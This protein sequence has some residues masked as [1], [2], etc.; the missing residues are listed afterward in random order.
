MAALI[1]VDVQY[2]FLPGGALAV[3]GSDAIL[4]PILNDLLPSPSSSSSPSNPWRLIIATQ[5]YHPPRHISFASIHEGAKVR[6]TRKVPHPIVKG[7][8]IEQVMWPDHCVRGTRGA[9]IEERVVRRLREVKEG[10]GEVAVVQKVGPT[11]DKLASSPQQADYMLP[12]PASHTQGTDPLVDGY[13][14]LSDNAYSRFT[15]LIRYLSSHSIEVVVVCG[16]A[17]DYC[18]LYT[19]MDLVKFGYTVVLPKDATRPVEAQSGAVEKLEAAGMR[20]VET[21]R[22]AREVVREMVSRVEEGR[23]KR[24]LEKFEE[25]QRRIWEEI[26]S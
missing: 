6:E 19:A 4:D 7:E 16:L 10:G 1:L 15:P 24:Y 21:G 26:Q 8:E 14:G 11:R 9:R 2:D 23:E 17:T 3:A 18:V 12:P 13:S 22:E 5:D 25:G 20:V